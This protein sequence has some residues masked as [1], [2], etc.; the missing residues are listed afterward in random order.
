VCVLSSKVV[1]S[2]KVSDNEEEEC[3]EKAEEF[4]QE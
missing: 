2:S 3:D 4:A 1:G